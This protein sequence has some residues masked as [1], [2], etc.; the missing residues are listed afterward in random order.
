[1]QLN[2]AQISASKL[3]DVF[4][5]AFMEVSALEENYFV[6]GAETCTS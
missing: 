6:V 4:S 3:A 2:E 5:G 1:M